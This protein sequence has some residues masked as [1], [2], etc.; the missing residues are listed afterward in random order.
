MKALNIVEDRV[1][2]STTYLAGSLHEGV[3]MKSWSPTYS[4]QQIRWLCPNI[5]MMPID[6]KLPVNSFIA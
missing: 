6:G 5:S 4:G 1:F 2:S 3:D